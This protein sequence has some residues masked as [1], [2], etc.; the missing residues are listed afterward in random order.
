[1]SFRMTNWAYTHSLKAGPKLLLVT[2]AD[3]AHDDGTTPAGL[4]Y[5]SYETDIPR[6]LN[7]VGMTTRSYVLSL[8]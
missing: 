6:V 7:R 4:E 5:L 2:I 1:M 8:L 3:K